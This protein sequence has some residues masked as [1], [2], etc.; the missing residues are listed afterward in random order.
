M[1]IF[2][3]IFCILLSIFPISVAKP[4][5]Y[6]EIRIYVVDGK[7]N[8]PLE[9][10]NICILEC[11]RYYKTDSLGYSPKMAVETKDHVDMP[12]FS[13]AKVTLLVYKE[14]YLDTIV[15][16]VEVYDGICRLGPTVRLFQKTSVDTKTQKQYDFP[17]DDLISS[18]IEKYRK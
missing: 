18:V 5:E 9:N 12:P 2:I 13:R 3:S 15:F 10:V 7:S 14:G 4:R 1:R 16:G 8:M 17:D 6:G 11:E